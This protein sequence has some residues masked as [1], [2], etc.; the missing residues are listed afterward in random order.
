[1]DSSNNRLFTLNYNTDC[2]KKL[3]SKNN[4]PLVILYG[5]TDTIQ[6]L[7]VIKF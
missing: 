1:M 5:K 6:Y 7:N 3:N 4:C 2:T